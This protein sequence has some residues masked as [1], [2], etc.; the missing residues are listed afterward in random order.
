MVAEV[1]E[2]KPSWSKDH[3]SAWDSSV[4]NRER[5][6]TEQLM[7]ALWFRND[8]VIARVGYVAREQK[9]RKSGQPQPQPAGPVEPNPFQ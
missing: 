2:L 4:A 9:D 8:N 1:N 6:S 3:Q 7:R 5:M